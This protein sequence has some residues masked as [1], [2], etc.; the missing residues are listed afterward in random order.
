MSDNKSIK[1]SILEKPA[2]KIPYGS[3]KDIFTGE[4]KLTGPLFFA[5]LAR[6]Y[7]LWA[8]D[9]KTAIKVSQFPYL[10]GIDDRL[11]EG[12]IRDKDIMKEANRNV[13]KLLGNRREL[14]AMIGVYKEGMTLKNLHKYD[15]SWL[16][17]EKDHAKV[18]AEA[19]TNA[20]DKSDIAQIFKDALYKAKG[21]KESPLW[22]DTESNPSK[23]T[24]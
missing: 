3:Y 7:L 5:E 18:S 20:V 17:A 2:Q 16:D 21:D 13:I 19:T 9:D 14:G 24:P 1:D 12:W 23:N 15:P 6:K 4:E 8:R 10:H 22:E 11:F